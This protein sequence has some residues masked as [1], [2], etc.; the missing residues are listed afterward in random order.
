[1][2]TKQKPHDRL[3]TIQETCHYLGI[4][5]PTFYRIASAGKIK[6]CRVGARQ[7]ISERELAAYLKGN[8]KNTNQPEYLVYNNEDELLAGYDD[9]DTAR[10]VLI[11]LDGRGYL[12]YTKL[13]K[14]REA[15]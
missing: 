13:I 4:S 11:S 2:Q 3:L 8:P 10:S 12:Q 14:I 9:I 7:R 6:T 1:M 15:I 5:R